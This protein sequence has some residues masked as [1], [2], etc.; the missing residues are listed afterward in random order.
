MC[1]HCDYVPLGCFSRSIISFLAF[2]REFV[3]F[4]M[5]TILILM[6][7]QCVGCVRVQ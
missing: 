5:L 2:S 7:M 3:H 6:L 1:H 4:F